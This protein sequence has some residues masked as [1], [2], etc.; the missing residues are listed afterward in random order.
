[1]NINYKNMETPEIV[2]KQTVNRQDQEHSFLENKQFVKST[3]FDFGK[4]MSIEKQ[5]LEK[6]NGKIDS[7]F[8]MSSKKLETIPK[9]NLI[10]RH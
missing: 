8:Q 1:M 4:I 3:N 10:H 9:V 7:Y 2:R 6:F 5:L